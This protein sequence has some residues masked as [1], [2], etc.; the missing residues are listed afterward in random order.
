MSFD[1]GVTVY[2]IAGFAE[3]FNALS[4][5]IGAVM[6]AALGLWMFCRARPGARVW[7]AIFTVTAVFLL[8]MS[9]VYHL[10]E[11]G[12]FAREEVFRRLDHAAIFV[13]IAGTSTAAHGLLFRGF[14]RW[15]MIALLWSSVA[16]AVTLTSVF[17]DAIP[18]LV[19]LGI[20]LAFGWL[21]AVSGF[22]VWQA[23]GFHLVSPLLL[24]GVAYTVGAV[25]Q[26][27]ADG[28]WIPGVFGAHGF[29]H[30]AVLAGLGLHSLFFWRVV[31]Q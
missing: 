23:A 21:G 7:L 24:G 17:F 22:K 1:S 2:A 15:G 13:L 26:F 5:L 30:I 10:L 28:L 20:Y 31:R 12:S 11:Y 25:A 14:W 29:F 6:F 16:I 19:K 3:P 4:H 27:S 9:G 8:S 18:E